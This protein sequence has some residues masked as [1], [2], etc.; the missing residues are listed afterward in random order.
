MRLQTKDA[1]V[2]KKF[3]KFNVKKGKNSSIFYVELPRML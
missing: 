1:G 3:D 2:L